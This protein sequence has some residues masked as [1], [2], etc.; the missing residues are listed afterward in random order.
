MLTTIV[1]CR[2]LFWA[3]ASSIHALTLSGLVFDPVCYSLSP[4]SSP[5]GF[6]VDSERQ[7]LY[8]L[9]NRDG[10]RLVV[11]QLEYTST[12]CTPNT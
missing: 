11:N 12:A 8:W 3:N 2:V 10:G 6:A 5:F 1:V 4:G 9:N 7:R